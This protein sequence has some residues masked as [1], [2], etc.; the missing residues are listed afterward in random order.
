MVVELL[1]KIFL[2]LIVALIYVCALCIIV[3][4]VRKMEKPKE[5]L[6]IILILCICL[7]ICAMFFLALVIVGVLTGG[8]MK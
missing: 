7:L 3:E 1:T 2:F 6:D 8:L 4:F 5:F